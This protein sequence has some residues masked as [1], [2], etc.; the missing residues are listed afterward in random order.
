[1]KLLPKV[2]VPKKSVAGTDDSLGRGPDIALSAAV[3]LLIGLAVDSVTNTRPL[4]TIALV[5]LSLV[6]NFASMW[7][8]YNGRMQQLEHERRENSVNHQRRG[9]IASPVE[10]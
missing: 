4:F 7:Y 2:L 10:S 8:V 9:T 1:M 6:G 5:V 3:F